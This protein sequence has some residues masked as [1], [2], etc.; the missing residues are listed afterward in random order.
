MQKL[1]E[2]ELRDYI[3]V[4]NAAKDCIKCLFVNNLYIPFLI[5]YEIIGI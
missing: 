2:F 5:N 4:Q 1:L 3:F